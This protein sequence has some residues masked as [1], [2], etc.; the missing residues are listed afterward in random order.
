LGRVALEASGIHFA[1]YGLSIDNRR[2]FIGA[3]ILDALTKR[4]EGRS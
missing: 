1:K 2:E 4:T 3:A